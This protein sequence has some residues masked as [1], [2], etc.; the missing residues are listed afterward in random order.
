MFHRISL[1]VTLFMLIYSTVPYILHAVARARLQEMGQVKKVRLFMLKERGYAISETSLEH[2]PATE[3]CQSRSEIPFRNRTAATS[4]RCYLI[5]S[6]HQGS[7][8]TE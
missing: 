7:S 8:C 5:R 2:V 1:Y 6:N 4:G 3:N